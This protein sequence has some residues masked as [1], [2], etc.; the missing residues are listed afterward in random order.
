M[1][2]PDVGSRERLERT[3]SAADLAA[4]ARLSGQDCAATILPE[5]LIDA[6]FSQLLGMQLP[7]IGS[8][9]L[10]QESIYHE[11]ARVGEMLTAEVEITRVR[12]DQQLVDL[13]TTCRG[14]G[15]RLLCS[16]RALVYIRD[17]QWARKV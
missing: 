16:G 2:R 1:S 17:V 10:K 15:G 4:Y 3:Y 7:G 6:L 11:P 14:D 8:N 9:Y 12:E 13:A 5:P